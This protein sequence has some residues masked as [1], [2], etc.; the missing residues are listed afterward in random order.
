MSVFPSL[1]DFRQGIAEEVR[2]CF[3]DETRSR[4]SSLEQRR[5]EL[6]AARAV[7]ADAH[8]KYK[9]ATNQVR[10][11]NSELRWIENQRSTY[12][13]RVADSAERLAQLRA[14]EPGLRIDLD[15]VQRA[16]DLAE[17]ELRNLAPPVDE[18]GYDQQLKIFREQEKNLNSR[19]KEWTSTVRE[20]ERDFE[21]AERNYEK[22]KQKHERADHN[23]QE[24]ESSAEAQ[25]RRL[26]AERSLDDLRHRMRQAESDLRDSRD[27]LTQLEM[28]KNRLIQPQEDGVYAQKMAE[29]NQ[30]RSA[31]EANHEQRRAE[32]EVASTAYE[33]N[34]RALSNE[35]DNQRR[36]KGEPA[37]LVEAEE[38]SLKALDRQQSLAGKYLAVSLRTEAVEA[39]ESALR[40]AT[41][42]VAEHEA[43]MAGVVKQRIAEFDS[44][45]L[46]TSGRLEQIAQHLSGWEE[47]NTLWVQ[48]SRELSAA[49]QGRWAQ[50]PTPF[51]EELQETEK[52]L[53]ELEATPSPQGRID[54]AV[55]VLTHVGMTPKQVEQ[56]EVRD[57]YRVNGGPKI[58]R[59]LASS[60]GAALF[61][62]LIIGLIGWVLYFLTGWPELETS[63]VRT[64]GLVIQVGLMLLFLWAFS[65]D[66]DHRHQVEL[67]PEKERAAR[68]AIQTIQKESA[69]LDSLTEALAQARVRAAEL[70][71]EQRLFRLHKQRESEAALD[72]FSRQHPLQLSASQREELAG[73]RSAVVQK[74][75]CQDSADLP[76]LE[77]T[78]FQARTPDLSDP[79]LEMLWTRWDKRVREAGRE[80][81]LES[82]VQIE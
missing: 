6:A 57:V 23:R 24:E 47:L 67:S 80:E 19:I 75:A 28:D 27:V 58:L 21:E 39:A 64:S 17:S 72:G 70:R 14:E 79:L 62:T 1:D 54:Q 30:R 16:L 36:L 31:I 13:Q 74:F 3:A 44:S 51:D 20:K 12:E 45:P 81:L 7:V 33:E 41:E 73:L 76:E 43:M 46:L 26:H 32:V 11:E 42:Q 35:K 15:R 66:E 82:R 59:L 49:Q 5:E 68:S 4:A 40:Q 38:R 69:D 63:T 78:R 34:Y 71:Q 61:F 48:E 22:E 37:D 2:A 25:A 60:F 52:Q 55:G 50:M 56:A 65:D 10:K 18:S 9:E 77:L 53:A 8:H 29:Y